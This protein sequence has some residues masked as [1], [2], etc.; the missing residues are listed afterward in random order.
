MRLGDRHLYLLREKH[1]SPIN[2]YTRSVG[3]VRQYRQRG[4]QPAAN[5]QGFVKSPAWSCSRAPARIEIT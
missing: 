2:H 5:Y 4:G 1:A 3:S